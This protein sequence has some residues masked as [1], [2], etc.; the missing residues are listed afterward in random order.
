M[1]KGK[2]ENEFFRQPTQAEKVEMSNFHNILKKK[3]FNLFTFMARVRKQK[4]YFPPVEFILKTCATA[5]KSNNPNLW[6]Y[7][8]KAL[9]EELPKHFADLNIKQAQELKEGGAMTLK[10]IMDGAR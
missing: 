3:R 5:V 9:K 10:Q 6:G 2:N 1:A 8:T 7:F 4:G